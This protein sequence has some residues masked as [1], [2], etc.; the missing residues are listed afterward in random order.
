MTRA[1]LHRP[2]KWT[3]PIISALT[4]NRQSSNK[5][6]CW[7]K[8]DGGI[9]S[10]LAREINFGYSTKRSQVPWYVNCVSKIEDQLI[11]LPLAFV[12]I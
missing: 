4:K 10:S 6:T 12:Q 11:H 7:T 1:K 8:R 9:E 5:M 3:R 2:T